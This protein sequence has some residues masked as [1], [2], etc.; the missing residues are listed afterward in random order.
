MVR[1]GF[2]GFGT[3]LYHI[4]RYPLPMQSGRLMFMIALVTE[5]GV[6]VWAH[7]M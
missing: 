6:G 3:T 5:C 4:Y 7:V 2:S 1:S